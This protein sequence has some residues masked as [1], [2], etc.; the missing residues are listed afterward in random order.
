[1]PLKGT[2]RFSI[3]RIGNHTVEYN[4]HHN[5]SVMIYITYSYRPFRLYEKHHVMDKQPQQAGP[6]F[7]PNLVWLCHQI[8]KHIP[9]L[10]GGIDEKTKISKAH[11][12]N[13]RE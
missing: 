12:K 1:M 6:H 10:R 13:R 5:G 2:A 7:W 9:I 11:K 4:I 3:E 8:K